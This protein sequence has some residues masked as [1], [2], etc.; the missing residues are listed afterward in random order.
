MAIIVRQTVR[1]AP[2][3]SGTSITLSTSSSPALT[4]TLAGS[5]LVIAINTGQGSWPPSSI[6]DSAGNTWGVIK[7]DNSASSQFVAILATTGTNPSPITS[8]TVTMNST[9][10]FALVFYELTGA[11][12]TAFQQVGASASSNGS[13]TAATTTATSTPSRADDLAIS[14]VAW[15][16]L[17]ASATADSSQAF[18]G[19]GTGQ[20]NNFASNSQ[21]GFSDKI[22]SST[23]QLTAAAAQTFT[24]T[25]PATTYAGWAAAIA[26]FQSLAADGSGTLTTD[27]SSVTPSSTGNTITFTYT[28][29]T[30]DTN[31]GAVTLVVP[32][33]WSAPSTTGANAG[34]TTAS[35]TGTIGTLSVASQTITIPSVTLT[36]GQTIT[37]TYGSTA[38]SGPGATA[39]SSTGVQTW[40]A[41]EKSASGGTLTNLAS[42]PSINVAPL[43]NINVNDTPAVTDSPALNIS[44]YTYSVAVAD[45]S[46]IIDNPVLDIPG[47]PRNINVNDTSA[48]TDQVAVVG[49][50]PVTGYLAWYDPSDASSIT[51]SSG[52]VSQ[53]SDK[54]ANAH[55][56]TASGTARPTTGTKTINGLN[57]LDFNG[58][59]NYLVSA[60][61]T[62]AQPVTIF[63]VGQKN[64]TTL[65]NTN[66]QII[67]NNASS[68]TIYERGTGAWA[69]YAG[70]EQGTTAADTRA[71]LWDAVFNSASSSL[72]IDSIQSSTGNRGSTGWSSN[73][74]NVGNS[75]GMNTG[76]PGQVAEII[77]YPSALS[78]TDRALVE[79]YFV[80]KWFTSSAAV[81]DTTS[82]VENISLVLSSPSISVSDT[83]GVTEN[84]VVINATNTPLISVN[85][86]TT[87]VDSVQVSFGD[88]IT[89]SNSSAISELTLVSIQGIS[90]LMIAASD[91]V[92]VTESG[93][94]SIVSLVLSIAVSDVVNTNESLA[95][96]RM[97]AVVSRFMEFF[98]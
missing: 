62:Q 49:L 48:T 74:I 60:N 77:I 97:L 55:H 72:N 18:T 11:H 94:V 1:Y 84:V 16:E 40:Q 27:T 12:M 44:G 41:Q 54:S 29:A 20:V 56:L 66:D 17:S 46:A 37:I 88:S 31:A 22:S 45:A 36:A 76:W 5:L 95:L 7:T 75:L 52:L 23:L 90:D 59:A 78:G 79:T 24:T 68:P 39:T 14:A 35:S 25:L 96:L 85:D 86:T 87:V 3:G 6:V 19:P 65:T 13:T 67:G 42:S 28:A 15:G 70:T 89:V 38:S 51:S 30:G 47:A 83:T 34:Y 32:A 71:H 69:F 91:G 93:L 92:G 43:V 4:T 63:V 98:E 80:T 61:I 53:L 81:S 57:V 64:S 2:S 26:L 50:P 9:E 58:G 73:S 33:G 8:V 82:L 10:Y 21:T